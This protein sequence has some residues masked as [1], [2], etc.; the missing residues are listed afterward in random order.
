VATHAWRI[1]L[2]DLPEE[3]KSWDLAVPAAD[4]QDAALGAVDA[5]PACTDMHWQGEIRRRGDVW[6]LVGR[7]RVTLRRQCDR[8][9]APFDWTVEGSLER[10]YRIAE[11]APDDDEEALAFPGRIDLIDVL[12]EEVWLAWRVRAVCREDCKGLCPCCGADLNRGD[13]GCA[14]QDEDHP[15]AVLRKLKLG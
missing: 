3:G 10:N 6:R 8:C 9:L 12:R 4:L 14:P 11:H 15:F 2:R 1:V 13:C 5:L 7:W